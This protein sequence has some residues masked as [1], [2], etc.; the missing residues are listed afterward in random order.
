[1]SE[2]TEVI[3]GD[4]IPKQPF[5]QKYSGWIIGVLALTLGS[6][7]IYS[8][9]HKTSSDVRVVKT[10]TVTATYLLA[11]L[12]YG[13]TAA[14]LKHHLS[15]GN[16]LYQV[17]IPGVADTAKGKD[18]LPIMDTVRSADSKPI[19]DTTTHKVKMAPRL[20]PH[21]EYRYPKYVQETTIT[22]R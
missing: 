7:I 1:M 16:I 22:P 20:L 21:L 10:D 13:A 2:T 19:L 3:Q 9:T 8:L 14:V 6:W 15:D 12:G 17:P 11:P 5:H 18:G 4:P